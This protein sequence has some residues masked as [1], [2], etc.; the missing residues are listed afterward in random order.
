[1]SRRALLSVS[2]KTGLKEFATG[3]Q[4]LGFDLIC[5]KNLP[6]VKA[7]PPFFF[8]KNQPFFDEP[9][10]GQLFGR[11]EVADLIFVILLNNT[12]QISNIRHLYDLNLPRFDPF[13]NFTANDL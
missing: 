1:M 6:F 3:L 13:F 10:D 5:F 4:G 9:T 7:Q 12:F 2:D 11:G 8:L